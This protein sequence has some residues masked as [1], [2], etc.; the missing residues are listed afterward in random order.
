[1]GFAH[2]IAGSRKP[3]VEG[4]FLAQAWEVDWFVKMNNTGGPVDVWAVDGVDE[5]R[6]VDNGSGYLYL[7]GAISNDV[8]TLVRTDV[9]PAERQSPAASE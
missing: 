9:P 1:M 2:G 5:D 8:L 6:L 4:C 3:E 7:P